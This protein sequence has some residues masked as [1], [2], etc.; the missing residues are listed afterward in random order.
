MIGG[1]VDDCWVSSGAAEGAAAGRVAVARVRFGRGRGI[2]RYEMRD[3][4]FGG[5]GVLIGSRYGINQTKWV[6]RSEL[7]YFMRGG[8]E[9]TRRET[10]NRGI[11]G[12]RTDVWQLGC[13]AKLEAALLC[14]HHFTAL[15]V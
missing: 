5:M 4:V 1:V 14:M 13:G 15:L 12:G 10:N 3:F 6:E 11:F 2:V 9:E 7:G 8:N